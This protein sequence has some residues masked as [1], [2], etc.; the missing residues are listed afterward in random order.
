MI[1]PQI[2]NGPHFNDWISSKGWPEGYIPLAIY[3][4]DN[5]DQEEIFMDASTSDTDEFFV[6]NQDEQN[7]PIYVWSHSAGLDK[8]ADSIEVFIK[9]LK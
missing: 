5:D 4:P 7:Y 3:S 2:L 9:E 1:V 8:W 6:I